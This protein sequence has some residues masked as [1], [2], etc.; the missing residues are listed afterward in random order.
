MSA[1]TLTDGD[2]EGYLFAVYRSHAVDV[3]IGKPA[4]IALLEEVLAS[5]KK[6]AAIRAVA[7][8]WNSDPDSALNVIIAILNGTP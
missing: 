7:E 5:R 8:P 3:R 2:V 1:P 4:S 6:L